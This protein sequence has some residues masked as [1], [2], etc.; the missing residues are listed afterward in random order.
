VWFEAGLIEA[1]FWYRWPRGTNEFP[2]KVDPFPNPPLTFANDLRTDLAIREEEGIYFANNY[3]LWPIA[4]VPGRR[5]LRESILGRLQ[6]LSD[7]FLIF[8]NHG[9]V[10]WDRRGGQRLEL[11]IP[12]LQ[13]WVEIFVDGKTTVWFGSDKGLYRWAKGSAEAPRR[14]R[15]AT[16]AVNVLH[17]AGGALWVGAEKGLFRWQGGERDPEPAMT[18]QTGKIYEIRQWG[19]AV[20]VGAENGLFR[21]RTDGQGEPQHTPGPRAFKAVNIDETRSALWFATD[22]GIFRCVKGSGE[23]PRAVALPKDREWV[24]TKDIDGSR[25]KL[26]NVHFFETPSTLWID[27]FGRLFR[28][29]EKS[30]GELRFT[31]IETGVGATFHET[32]ESLLIGA[33]EGLFRWDKSADTLQ[34]MKLD[35]GQ[36]RAFHQ[37]GGMLRIAGGKGLFQMKLTKEK[38]DAALEVN[39]KPAE[40]LY[41]TSYLWFAWEIGRYDWRTTPD[42]VETRLLIHASD[43][44]RQ[45]WPGKWD[46]EQG[47]FTLQTSGAKTLPVGTYEYAVEA[48]DLL[49][50]VASTPRRRLVVQEGPVVVFLAWVQWVAAW[51]IG[52]YAAVSLLSFL[53][54]VLAARHW[55]VGLTILTHPW[56]L[57]FGIY[58]G[59]ALRNLPPLQV[60]VLARYHRSARLA[61]KEPTHPHIPRLL[62]RPRPPGILTTD[63]LDELRRERR[64][65]V[66][67]GPGTGKTETVGEILRG[68]FARTGSAWSGWW[69]FGF[70]PVLVRLRDTPEA[71]LERILAAVLSRHGLS[72]GD[73]RFARGFLRSAPLLFILDGV[74][75]ARLDH[76]QLQAWLPDFLQVAPRARVLATSQTV[77]GSGNLPRYEMPPLT[78]E[79]ARELLRAFLGGAAGT[80][81]YAA[82]PPDLWDRPE[83]LT[84]YEV[85]QVADLARG[86]RPVPG[87]RTELY[88]ATLEGATE[89]VDRPEV[90]HESLSR[91][92]WDAWLE[93]RYRFS[94]T[95]DLPEPLPPNLLGPVLVRRGVGAGGKEEYEFVHELMRAYLAARWAVVYATSPVARLDD[96]EVWRPSPSRRSQSFFTFLAELIADAEE[97]QAVAEFALEAPGLRAGLLDAVQQVA[98]RRAWVLQLSTGPERAEYLEA[99]CHITEAELGQVI[100]V[101]GL[102]PADFPSTPQRARANAVFAR[103][104]RLKRLPDLREQIRTF[105]PDAP[106]LER[107]QVPA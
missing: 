67:G 50:N 93:G 85:R 15:L 97:M 66:A 72:F 19:D 86:G 74:N 35:V 88:R 18:P 27:A 89:G 1:S 8:E 52:A 32:E 102:E 64:I 63:L 92:A 34:Q 75:E 5:A 25:G 90:V 4:E 53:S 33:E 107:Y 60:W 10:H 70:I 43:G 29:T 106:L 104:R 81:A 94:A 100:I 11:I 12:N 77:E 3:D 38:W 61:N 46:A 21:Y 95:A 71:S 76:R 59:W 73:E 23:A 20:W 47:H 56:V 84:A 31:G 28:T 22:E 83:G 24:P 17:D 55:P 26:T 79:F 101:M 6:R 105:Y 103:C 14:L 30:P 65:W 78:G 69:R 68:Y 40:P 91:L 99:L 49:G 13:C 98:R 58:Y 16:G 48:V 82:A 2:V 39:H 9:L 54:L 51:T 96:E 42:L 87:S 36:V 37:T 45:E 7:Q 62:S 41:P 44:T 80:A 57:R